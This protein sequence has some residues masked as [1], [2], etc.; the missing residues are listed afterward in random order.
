MKALDLVVASS[1]AVG[2]QP[3]PYLH[4]Q[5]QRDAENLIEMV[6]HATGRR[7]GNP[8]ELALAS[9]SMSREDAVPAVAAAITTLE[10]QARANLHNTTAAIQAVRTA[11]LS[12]KAEYEAKTK[13]LA[14]EL[15]QTVGSLDAKTRMLDQEDANISVAVGHQNV[16]LM[17][18]EEEPKALR[19]ENAAIK[20]EFAKYKAFFDL[21]S[22]RDLESV[23]HISIL[24]LKV[25][26][27]NI[28][29][30]AEIMRGV[31]LKESK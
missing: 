4:H 19:A 7:M 20:A 10:Y 18:V 17:A 27:A 26:S 9:C 28:A 29:Q 25:P 21:I 1:G 13:R 15:E 22:K 8:T 31:N 16:R 3:E 23:C 2:P 14:S 12:Q 6:H 11:S 30:L 5:V 24:S